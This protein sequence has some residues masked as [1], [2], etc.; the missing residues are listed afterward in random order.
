MKQVGVALRWMQRKKEM[1]FRKQI[2][3]YV[4]SVNK[5]WRRSQ[6]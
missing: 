6:R 5:N 4:L 3:F 2:K 1:R